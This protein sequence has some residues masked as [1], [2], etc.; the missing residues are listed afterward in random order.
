MFDVN[1]APV[2]ET[3]IKR[4]FENY[5]RIVNNQLLW[6]RSNGADSPFGVSAEGISHAPGNG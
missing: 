5:S 1:E 2:F 6:T 3:E 4:F